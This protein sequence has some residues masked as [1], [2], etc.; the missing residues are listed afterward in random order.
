MYKDVLQKL[1][2]DRKVD[3]NFIERLIKNGWEE[4]HC[5]YYKDIENTRY[6]YEI[7]ANT[8]SYEENNCGIIEYLCEASLEN[9]E[10]IENNKF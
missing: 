9:L 3:K 10:K 8:F 5:C 7:D 6:Y 2:N 4:G 1:N